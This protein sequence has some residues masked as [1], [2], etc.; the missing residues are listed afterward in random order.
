MFPIEKN[1]WLK[2]YQAVLPSTNSLRPERQTISYHFYEVLILKGNKQPM[3]RKQKAM[4]QKEKK[5]S[6]QNSFLT[7]FLYL[8]NKILANWTQQCIKMIIRVST[9]HSLQE[10]KQALTLD[11]LPAPQPAGMRG[12]QS[13]AVL[14]GLE[15]TPSS[16]RSRACSAPFRHSLS[17]SS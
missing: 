8:L 6:S 10:L 16:H 13:Q 15:T 1:T 12:A 2:V 11:A 14:W 7:L 9:M 5:F 4:H 3:K 17:T